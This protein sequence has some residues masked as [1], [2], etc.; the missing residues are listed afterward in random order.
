MRHRNGAGFTYFQVFVLLCGF[1]AA[2]LVI[3]LLGFVVGKRQT[4]DVLAR[5]ERIVLREMPAPPTP[6]EQLSP[7]DQE[8][9]EAMKGRAQ[10]RLQETQAAVAAAT[11]TA[12]VP[13]P[14]PVAAARETA[15]PAR[16]TARPTPTVAVAAARPTRPT[17]PTPRRPP[18][19]AAG[20]EWADAGWTVQV[21]ATTD[22]RQA[23]ELA[24][25][26][27]ARGYDAYTIQAPVRGQTWYRVRV[28][29][30]AA[31]EEAERLERRLRRQEGLA[32]AYV[33]P[34]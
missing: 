22:P 21:N 4:E 26:L 12:A 13:P 11:A 24:R 8:F 10:Q 6:A 27:R 23:Q 28:G 17:A 2:S 9:F 30:F 5:D 18:A 25:S 7:P 33:T 32:N 1:A 3:F 14:L 19:A 15:P 34:R 16:P 29:R 31:R 20:G